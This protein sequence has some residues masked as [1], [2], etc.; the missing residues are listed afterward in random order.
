PL[1]INQGN[2]GKKEENQRAQIATSFRSGC[3]AIERADEPPKHD[4]SNDDSR[5]PKINLKLHYIAHTKRR[6]MRKV[7]AGHLRYDFRTTGE[8]RLV[9]PQD[10]RNQRE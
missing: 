7:K 6:R 4:K 3:F 8:Y 2:G 9:W 1:R 10:A 5:N